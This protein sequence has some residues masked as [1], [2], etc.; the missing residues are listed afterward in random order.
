[1]TLL[2]GLLNNRESNISTTIWES[3]IS[4]TIGTTLSHVH[5]P[6]GTSDCQQNMHKL[7]GC[8]SELGIPI[9]Q[10]K[11]EDTTTC[12]TFLGIEVDT[13]A[14]ELRLPAQRLVRVCQ[15]VSEWLG[16]KAARRR[17]LE[18]LVGTL[19]HATKVVRPGRICTKTDPGDVIS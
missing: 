10:D 16:R 9:A 3:N 15:T 6:P 1:M 19:Q 8:C 4:T 13:Q 12:L 5:G 11:T 2:N 17:E 18:S 7:L 14:M